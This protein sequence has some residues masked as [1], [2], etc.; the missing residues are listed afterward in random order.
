MLELKLAK[1]NKSNSK[2]KGHKGNGNSKIVE[3]LNGV[4]VG[5]TTP[6]VGGIS[7]YSPQRI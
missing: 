3:I 6:E 5:D 7:G 4:T 1:Q 2:T